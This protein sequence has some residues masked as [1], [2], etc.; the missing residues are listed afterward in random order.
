MP[1]RAAHLSFV[2]PGRKLPNLVLI[3]FFVERSSFVQQSWFVQAP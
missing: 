2:M 1:I 3:A